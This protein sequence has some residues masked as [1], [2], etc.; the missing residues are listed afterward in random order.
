MHAEP[1]ILEAELRQIVA[2]DRVRV[3]VVLLQIPAEAPPLFVFSPEKPGN[4]QD[5]GG[6]NRRDDVDGNVTAPDH[7]CLGAKPMNFGYDLTDQCSRPPRHGSGY[8]GTF[9]RVRRFFASA[10]RRSRTA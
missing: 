5:D 1:E 10:H 7:F 4:Q 3:E 9:R 8:T 2:V 6:D